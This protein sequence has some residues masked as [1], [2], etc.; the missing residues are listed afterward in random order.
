VR[1]AA[2]KL[3][4]PTS[5]RCRSQSAAGPP[6]RRRSGGVG[7]RLQRGCNR[8]RRD[9]SCC[10]RCRGMVVFRLS[11]ALPLGASPLTLPSTI[12]DRMGVVD[13]ELTRGVAQPAA[14]LGKLRIG[15]WLGRDAQ[16]VVAH[17]GILPDQ[18]PQA[19]LHVAI[20]TDPGARTTHVSC[21]WSKSPRSVH[22]AARV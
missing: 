16:V 6:S 10:R 19:P 13:S 4:L 7:R 9:R 8:R 3:L 14:A 15:D 1:R 2:P 5:P 20:A 18:G 11:F 17:K 12:V 22:V 21:R